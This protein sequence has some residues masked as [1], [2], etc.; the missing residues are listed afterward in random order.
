MGSG[1]PSAPVLCLPPANRL[2]ILLPVLLGPPPPPFLSPS[3]A[4]TSCAEPPGDLLSLMARRVFASRNSY[5][6]QRL[7]R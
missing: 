6:M 4:P 7:C 2:A 5:L 1:R 3:P